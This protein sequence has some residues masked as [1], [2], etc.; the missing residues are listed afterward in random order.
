[1]SKNNTKEKPKMNKIYESIH[2]S[3]EK[4]SFL[5]S[6]CEWFYD[7]GI[8]VIIVAIRVHSTGFGQCCDNFFIYQPIWFILA[9]K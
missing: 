7:Q 4:F 2:L 1:M 9:L 5:I 6:F 8:N 3:K